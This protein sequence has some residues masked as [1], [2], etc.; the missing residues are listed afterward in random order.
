M[1]SRNSAPA[2]LISV[3]KASSARVVVLDPSWLPACLALDHRALNGFWSDV[4]WQRE[5]EDPQRLCLGLDKNG[6]LLGFACG[7]LVVDE[8]QI[9]AVA[10]DPD[11]RRLGC[12]GQLLQALL[13]W[14]QQR[15]AR[16]ATLEVASNN[17]AALALYAAEGFTTAG[18]RSGY[19]SDGRDAL[20][21]WLEL[22]PHGG[23]CD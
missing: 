9:T 21:Q 7:W 11:H 17:T 16:H 13:Q 12:G 5:L 8:L 22:P 2:C 15:G 1:Q 3:L 18:C 10:I 6:Q 19:Y 14:A 20:I 23:R 4:Q